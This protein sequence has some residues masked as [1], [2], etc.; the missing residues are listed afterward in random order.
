LVPMT[1]IDAASMEKQA[2]RQAI[3]KRL[4]EVDATS[5]QMPGSVD[6]DSDEAQEALAE[7]LAKG[8][9]R[10]ARAG[11]YYLDETKVTEAKAGNGFLALLI[12]L[13]MVSVMASAIALAARSG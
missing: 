2:A 13:V 4:R 11:L 5:A 1:T 7:L 8:E 3:I 12:I 6:V 9:V 10:Q